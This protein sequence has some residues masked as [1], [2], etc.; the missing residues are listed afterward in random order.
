M[1]VEEDGATVPDQIEPLTVLDKPVRAPATLATPSVAAHSLTTAADAMRDEEVERTRLFIRMGWGISAASIGVVPILAAPVATQIAMVAAMVIGMVVSFGYH[2]QF[3]D[4]AKYT[5]RALVRLA[6]MCIVN[7]HV[8]VLYF[9]AFSI[10]PIIV[11]IGIHFV[12]R[13]EAERAARILYYWAIACYGAI[14]VVLVPGIVADP[15]VFATAVPL[16][17]ATKL[18]GAVFVL[19][20]YTLAYATARVFRRASLAS[21]EEL[22]RATRLA[23]QREALMDELRADLERALRVG[24]PGRYSD[25]TL[26]AYK[27]G[28][29]IGRGAI[30]E[31]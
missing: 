30:G 23:S 4:P 10:S 12:A 31:V 28:I 22:S 13:T 3:A 11:V 25:Q 21:I 24:G 19:G 20:T 27:L 16:S 2:Q 1:P 14:A 15:G 8:A 7:A 5:E 9:G 6:V 18:V 29:V 17:S 26:G